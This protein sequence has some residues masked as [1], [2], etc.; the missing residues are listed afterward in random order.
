MRYSHPSLHAVANLLTHITSILPV[1]V[2]CEG[3]QWPGPACGALARL[4]SYPQP[5]AIA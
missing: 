5:L 2:H 1:P 3:W 4:A